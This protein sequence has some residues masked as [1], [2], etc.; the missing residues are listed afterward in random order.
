M[1]LHENHF[2]RV[3]LRLDRARHVRTV[4]NNDFVCAKVRLERASDVREVAKNGFVGANH[5]HA[6]AKTVRKAKT[7][8][9]TPR[10]KA[11]SGAESL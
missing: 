3:N 8:R 7:W 10:T 9:R 2:G 6:F 11:P 4:A 5:P 1:G